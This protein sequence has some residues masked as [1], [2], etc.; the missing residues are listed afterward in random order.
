MKQLA[1]IGSTASGK[2]DLA[3]Q[4]ALNHNAII[5]SIDS[6][7]IY[8][9]I[10]I[11]SAK[12][13]H[14]ELS[15]VK[16]FGIDVLSPN[17]TATVFT[18]I[19]EYYKAYEYA[20]LHQKNI[21]IVGGSSFYLKSM[22]D[23]LSFVP[24]ISDETKKR[25]HLM[26]QN[27]YETHTFLSQIDPQTMAK[28]TPTDSYRLEK[29]LHLYLETKTPPS[30]WFAQHPPQPIITQ[31][32]ILSID[33]ERPMLRERIE[34]RTRKMIIVGLIDE[35]ASLEQRYGRIPNSMKAI[36]VIETLEFLDGKID[37]KI[38]LNDISTHTVQLAKRQQTFNANQFEGYINGNIS[39]LKEVIE[40]ILQ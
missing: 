35:V 27:L 25:S 11:A 28:I 10:N 31:C 20:T 14:D 24:P 19:D 16:H 22:L 4:T 36:G 13:T 23:G 1:I 3:L 5:L 37:K 9:E 40:D 15:S 33:I 6:L 29:M 12:P 7:S 17:E 38:L 8:K 2:S 39:T 26:L 32:P 30:Q 34:L 21:I 18:F